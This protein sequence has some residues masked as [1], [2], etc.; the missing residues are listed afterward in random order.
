MT[1]K[2]ITLPITGMTCANCA[3][4]IERNLKKLAGVKAASVNLA[5]ERAT[6]VY[7]QELIGQDRIIQRISEVGYGVA[8]AKAEL[9]IVGMTCANCANTIERALKKLP[10][11][12]AA[13][14]NLATERATIEYLP[15]TV[16]LADLIAT[17]RKAGYDV[18]ETTAAAEPEDVER[19]AREA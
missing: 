17:I 16:E 4:T 8:T 12:T 13:S 19:A 10:G 11:V 1:E 18:V 7:D 9:P 3:N 15:G 6:V 14:V 5:S 2:Q